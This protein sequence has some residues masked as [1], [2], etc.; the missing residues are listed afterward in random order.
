MSAITKVGE[1]VNSLQIII[2]PFILELYSYI[3]KNSILSAVLIN[4]LTFNV[5]AAQ[6]DICNILE[7]PHDDCMY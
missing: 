5:M 6:S 7:E 3:M 1:A 2:L 4:I